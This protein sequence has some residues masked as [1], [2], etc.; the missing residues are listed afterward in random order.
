MCEGYEICNYDFEYDM[1]GQEMYGSST[2]S[3]MQELINLCMKNNIQAR[4]FNPTIDQRQ[5][6]EHTLDFDIKISYDIGKQIV[7]NF[8]QGK[9]HFLQSYSK[10]GFHDIELNDINNFS[11][12]MKDEWIDW[13][14]FDVSDEYLNYLNEFTKIQRYTT[15]P[16]RKLFVKGEV[17]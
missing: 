6:F 12:E 14:G 13:N 16:Q 1:A 17:I 3:S 2:S 8:T 5:N 11:R 10:S 9:S 4:G 7:H 15:V